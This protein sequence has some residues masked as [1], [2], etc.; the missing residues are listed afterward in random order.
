MGDLASDR[1]A[2]IE[3]II[4]EYS[5]LKEH[6]PNHKL[7]QYLSEVNDNGFVYSR[8]K[9]VRREFVD[10]YAPDDKTP[11]AVMFTKYFVD[12]RDAVDKIEG[13]DRSPK[14]DDQIKISSIKK[15]DDIDWENNPPF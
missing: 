14:K 10:K 13:I 11:V 2:A 9:K 7:L 3:L 6:D 5:R 4:E 12:L 8:D 1:Y 15:L